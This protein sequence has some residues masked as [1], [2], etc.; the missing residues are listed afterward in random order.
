MWKKH[1]NQRTGISLKVISLEKLSPPEHIY[2]E[3]YGCRYNFGDTAKLIEVLKHKGSTIVSSAEEA[4]AV[5]I[6]TCTVVGPTERRMLRRLSQF[7]DYNLFVMGCMPVVQSEAIFAVCTPAIISSDANPRGV[8]EYKNCSRW[9]GG[10]CP[11]GTGMCQ[12]GART[13]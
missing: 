11:G 12:A 7:R 6:N 10:D 4:D 5:I 8:P 3:T 9:R 2:I 1:R 13:V